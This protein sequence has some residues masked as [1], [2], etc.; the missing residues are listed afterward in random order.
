MPPELTC[1]SCAF[2]GAVADFALHL[3]E[4]DGFEESVETHHV[5]VRVD[6]DLSLQ[7]PGCGEDAATATAS[8]KVEM[9][10]VGEG[11]PSTVETDDV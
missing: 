11:W 9:T 10:P 5:E 7:C 4:I 3:D 2:A 1:P 8:G 6:V